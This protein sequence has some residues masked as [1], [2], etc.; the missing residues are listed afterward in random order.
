MPSYRF[1]FTAKINRPVGVPHRHECA[2]DAE[3][4]IKA[5]E[6]M[7]KS[8]PHGVALEVWEGHRLV[9]RI[10]AAVKADP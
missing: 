7:K 8:P 1:Y 3:A 5:R 4:M 9:G 10:P 2:D 6:I